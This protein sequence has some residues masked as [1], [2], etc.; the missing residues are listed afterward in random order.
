MLSNTPVTSHPL[1][2]TSFPPENASNALSYSRS[3]SI[4]TVSLVSGSVTGGP[5]KKRARKSKRAAN[6]DASMVGGNAKSA[7]SNNSGGRGRKRASREISAEEEDEGG[8]EMAVEMVARTQEE[9]QKEVEHRALLVRAFD[10]DQFS[11]YEAWRSSRL[12]DSVVR[13]VC[14]C[15]IW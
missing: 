12:Q 3:P 4:D 11:R 2:Q 6:D 15:L 7:L 1:R 14:H 10:E 8:E 9:R 5:K 13:R